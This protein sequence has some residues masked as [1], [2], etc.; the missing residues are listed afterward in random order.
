V[1][2]WNTDAME[3]RLFM[4]D[5]CCDICRFQHLAEGV[6]AESIRIR[7]D[8]DL[9]LPGAFADIRITVPGA[10]PY[11]IEVKWTQ[12]CD[13]IVER[14]AAKYSTLTPGS[15]DA[16]K[17][18]VASGVPECD[19][20]KL[21]SMLRDN[22]HPSLEIEV[23]DTARLREFVRK[24][25][26]TE[27]ASFDPEEL[28]KLRAAIELVKGSY[29]FGENY[30][31]SPAEAVLKWHFGCWTIRRLRQ[32][33]G[34]SE[35]TVFRSGL[36]TDVATLMVDLSGFSSYVR[37]T[38]DQGVV[39]Q[40]LTSFYTKSRRAVINHGGMLYQF[41]GD[42]VIGVFGVPAV[43]PGYLDAAIECAAAIMDIGR[44]VSN[45]WQRL[46]DRIQPVAGCHTGVALGDLLI[47]PLRSYSR[48]HFGL[49]AD[50][51][52]MAARLSSAARP[53]EMVV[54]NALFQGLHHSTKHPFTP[55]EPIEAKNVGTLQ[56]WKWDC[57]AARRA[58]ATAAGS[59]PIV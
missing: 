39:Q 30:S 14:I 44:S 29:A 50:S 33:P 55:M 32:Q 1:S 41:V 47:V 49:V 4:E 19:G 28:V 11:F 42:A 38:R 18:I 7:Q 46:T 48:S 53:G 20:A 37:D 2:I 27:I 6:P 24:Y 5:L 57:D 26:N 13:E 12:D 23:W 10:R 58:H 54:S 40:V 36:Y 22:V 43:W 52:N 35:A 59:V 51:V 8:F 56:A 31:H 45:K 9:G 16:A 34:Y 25:L 3:L 17:V 21:A 15:T